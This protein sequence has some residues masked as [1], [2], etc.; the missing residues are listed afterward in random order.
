MDK[1]IRIKTMFH[2]ILINIETKKAIE[3]SKAKGIYLVRRKERLAALRR[4]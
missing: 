1:K 3:I 4:V 2:N